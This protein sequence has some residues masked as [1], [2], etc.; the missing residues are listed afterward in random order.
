[1]KEVD[2]EHLPLIVPKSPE[3][4][5]Y[6]GF[7]FVNLTGPKISDRKTKSLVKRHVMIDIGKKRR[8]PHPP[9]KQ[10]L[11]QAL[12]ESIARTRAIALS[13]SEGNSDTNEELPILEYEYTPFISRFSS[14]R[15]D[16]FTKYPVKLTRRIGA[17]L[18]HSE[19]F[20]F[21]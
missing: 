18:D 3:S 12:S 5:R 15:L 13:H 19:R 6:A 11:L 16:P 17:L 20:S 1:M 8:K 2:S 21:Y 14:S 9:K 4:P 7:A 10:D